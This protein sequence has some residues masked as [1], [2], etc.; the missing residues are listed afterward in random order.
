MRI[1]RLACV[2]LI[3]VASL[4][5]ATAQAAPASSPQAAP[6]RPQATPPSEL[7]ERE[8]AEREA[9]PAAASHLPPTATVIT[10]KGLCDAAPAKTAD[11]KP[12]CKTVITRA[13]FEKI[14]DTL[15][16]NMPSQVRK[17]LA[18]EYPQILY[19]SQEARKRGLE[20]D[21]H[22]IE[23]LRF[24][25]LELL[26]L[27]LERSMEA[28]AGKIPD[29]DIKDFYD[30]NPQNYQQASLQRIF[31]PK[32][33]QTDM[34]KEGATPDELEKF[35]SESAAAMGKVADGLHTRAAAGEDFDKLQ[36]EA[37]EAAGVKSSPPPTANQKMPR[38]GLPPSQG[39]VF[40]L[41]AG[42]LSPVINDPQGFYIYRLVSKNTVP[43]SEA[44]NEIR[45]TL[46]S[47]RLQAARA[48]MQNAISSDLNSDYFGE[49]SPGPPGMRGG[50]KP[51]NRPRPT[52]PA[53]Q[54]QQ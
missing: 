31:I 34:P 29:S 6:Q 50:P 38:G 12:E 24:T 30:K 27:E 15:Q 25:K 5:F 8:E 20:K 9:A 23:M 7:E 18:L 1:L 32:V 43:L 16:P 2:L 52:P 19:M 39:T 13:E 46:R 17:Q 40:D 53:A 35:R 10:I 22:Y 49:P 3:T 41:K 36:K 28:Q 33:R 48:K 44:K 51:D 14:A 47:Q 4:R 45:S 42:E 26:K 21:P 37:Y 54:P 11:S